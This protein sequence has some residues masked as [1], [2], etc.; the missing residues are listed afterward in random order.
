MDCHKW[1]SLNQTLRRTNQDVRLYL[2]SIRS[3]ENRARECYEGKISLSSDEFVQCMLLDGFFILELFRGF[4]GDFGSLGYSACDPVF[5][6]RG[7]MHIIQRDMI[8]LENQI[9]L[10]VLDRILALQLNIPEN[11]RG[12]LLIPLILGFFDPLMP[13]GGPYLKS[14]SNA[15]TSFDPLSQ[16]GLHCLD[17]FHR[18]LLRKESQLQAPKI[19]RKHWS[20]TKHVV[21]RR[22]QQLVSCVTDLQEAGVRFRKHQTDRFWDIKFENG[23]LY[24]PR[25]MIH[26]G[27]KSLFLNLMAFEQCQLDMSNNITSYVIF[28][29]N[30][31]N[32]GEDV[33]HLH[34]RGIIEHWLGNDQEVADLFNNLCQEVVFDINDSYLSG[35]SAQVNSHYY[36]RWNIW[37]ATLRHRYF[38]NPWAIISFIAAVVLLLLTGV[39]T[40]YG[41][42]GFYKPPN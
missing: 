5:A 31:I 37:K 16:D 39:Q 34:Y 28:M 15:N 23:V 27:T 35:L 24:I 6:M 7:S 30:I 26:D 2:D 11:Q 33:R 41:V 25:L 4:V 14:Q 18:S 17:V 36:F 9:P 29:D 32:S 12:D 19:W 42:F 20:Q 13:T 22:R 1:R 38:N 21:D 40:F 3:L 8:M 10:F